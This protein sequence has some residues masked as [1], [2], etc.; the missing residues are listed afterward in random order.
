MLIRDQVYFSSL[1][2]PALKV[3]LLD[4]KVFPDVALQKIAVSSAKSTI[5]IVTG[6]KSH[7]IDEYLK[8]IKELNAS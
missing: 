8:I 2:F 1:I 3:L 6:M 7:L 4:F 5:I